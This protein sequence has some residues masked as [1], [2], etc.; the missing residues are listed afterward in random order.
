MLHFFPLLFR[1]KLTPE[2]QKDWEKKLIAYANYVYITDT[3]VVGIIKIVQEKLRDSTAKKVVLSS[4]DAVIAG[5]Q[6]AYDMFKSGYEQVK[7]GYKPDFTKEIPFPPKPP[8]FPT[9]KDYVSWF[10]LAWNIIESGLN[11]AAQHSSK[12]AEILPPLEAAGD[13]LVKD[14][15]KYFGAPKKESLQEMD[16]PGSFPTLTKHYA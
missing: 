13:Q 8:G 3:A 16:P 7:K 1:K 12:L 4:C 5:M 15:K 10:Q 9:D 2:Q 6:K 11:L 14:L